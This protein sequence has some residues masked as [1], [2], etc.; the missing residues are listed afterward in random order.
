MQ[1]VLGRIDKRPL[2]EPEPAVDAQVD[3]LKAKRPAPLGG[4][5]IADGRAA[6]LGQAE[7]K[8]LGRGDALLGHIVAQPDFERGLRALL[9]SSLTPCGLLS[10]AIRPISRSQVN[11]G[12]RG[13]VARSKA[14]T[15]R[16]ARFSA[17]KAGSTLAL[18]TRP[19][20]RMAGRIAMAAS[21]R[22]G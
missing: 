9:S 13:S 1:L 12:F 14:A 19:K 7:R 10:E 11:Q 15:T 3:R 22:S 5:R 18:A 17:I 20:E 8:L 16:I 2:P 6:A 21:R 4:Q